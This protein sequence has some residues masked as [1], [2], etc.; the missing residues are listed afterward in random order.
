MTGEQLSQARVRADIARDT[1]QRS[2]PSIDEVTALY[3]PQIRALDLP[4]R[5]STCPD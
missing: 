4:R 5:A 3:A 1:A 2:H